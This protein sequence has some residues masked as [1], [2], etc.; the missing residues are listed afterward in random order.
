M[1]QG[2]LGEFAVEVVRDIV[3]DIEVDFFW[4]RCSKDDEE[5]LDWGGGM[6]GGYYKRE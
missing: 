2:K 1:M 3:G 4:V 5:I 6:L